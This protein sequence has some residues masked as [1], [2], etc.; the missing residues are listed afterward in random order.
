[1][2]SLIKEV[3]LQTNKDIGLW[4]YRLY[5]HIVNDELNIFKD[6]KCQNEGSIIIYFT[7]SVITYQ[8]DDIYALDKTTD[9]KYSTSPCVIC[10]KVLCLL[11][12]LFVLIEMMVINAYIAYGSMRRTS[13]NKGIGVF[14]HDCFKATY[15]TI[16]DFRV[17][18]KSDFEKFKDEMVS[19][20]LKDGW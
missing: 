19:R 16:Y 3:C 12:N 18:S 2:Y 9:E 17:H 15:G 7:N 20:L 14:H 13:T 10:Q 5:S 11:G 4:L 8:K 6:F 1:M